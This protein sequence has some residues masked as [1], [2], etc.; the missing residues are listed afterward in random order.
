MN[1]FR[2]FSPCFGHSEYMHGGF[3]TRTDADR[4]ASRVGPLALQS[5]KDKRHITCLGLSPLPPS[6]YSLFV[7]RVQRATLTQGTAPPTPSPKSDPTKPDDRTIESIPRGRPRHN[8]PVPLDTHSGEQSIFTVSH[9]F[10]VEAMTPKLKFRQSRAPGR[11]N[12]RAYLQ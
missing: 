4:T 1:P 10:T 6:P 11:S 2:F 7:R 9:R 5:Q 3:R 12:G 8:C